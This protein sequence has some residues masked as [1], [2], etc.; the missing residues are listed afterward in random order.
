MRQL[1]FCSAVTCLLIVTSTGFWRDVVWHDV[2]TSRHTVSIL[3]FLE[4]IVKI[5]F[6]VVNFCRY[7]IKTSLPE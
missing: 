5:E 2:A 7:I 6:V 4:L 3:T 1:L